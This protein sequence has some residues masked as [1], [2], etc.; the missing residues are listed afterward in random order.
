MSNPTFH[1]RPA[2]VEDVDTILQLIIDLATYEKEP[3]SVKAT[4]QILRQNLFDTP[5]AHTLLAFDGTSEDPGEPIGMALYFF[6]YSTW[7]GRPGLYLE[8]LYVKPECRGKGIGKAF[9]GELGKIAQ[10]KN[11]PRLDWSVLKW[12]QPSIDFYEK[13]LGA[14]AMSGWMGMRLEEQG[15][16]N[17]RKFVDSSA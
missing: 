17:L 2:K 5:Y 14:K 13:T 4:P 9:F 6:N 8:D 7:T 3:E 15:I 12:N 1:I 16:D 10:E 11:C